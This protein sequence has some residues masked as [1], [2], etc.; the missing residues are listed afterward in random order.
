MRY[1]CVLSAHFAGS[2]T[3]SHSGRM[4]SDNRNTQ[5]TKWCRPFWMKWGWG[6]DVMPNILLQFP[7]NLGLN[8]LWFLWLIVA[9]G[10][11]CRKD[12][13]NLCSFD[14]RLFCPSTHS[15]SSLT[16]WTCIGRIMNYRGYTFPSSFSNPMLTVM[17]RWCDNRCHMRLFL[18]QYDCHCQGSAATIVLTAHLILWEQPFL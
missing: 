13:H 3:I 18:P 4:E 9:D 10:F 8:W 14:A 6:R 17:C 15:R 12:Y 7:P 11:Y 1:P 2:Y 16:Q 5:R